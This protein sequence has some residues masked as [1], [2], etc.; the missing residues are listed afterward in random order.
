M[1]MFLNYQNIADNYRPNNLVCSF[2]VGKSYTKLDPVDASKPFEEYDAKGDLIG[3]S[4]RYG[5]TLNLEFNIDGEIVVES[6]CIIYAAHN[7]G[8]T[9]LTAGYVGRRA[10]NILD[11]ISW[12]CIAVSPDE[13]VFLWEQ[14]EIFEHDLENATDS[15][16]VSA[17]DYL[18]D[19]HLEL[20]ICNFRYETVFSKVFE[21]TSKL[22]FNIDSILSKQLVKGIYYCELTVLGDDLVTPIFT[23][24]DC[25]FL[26]K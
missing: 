3:Y 2:P 8:P 18:A 1:G 11:F 26:V 4:W 9:A 22:I 17:T 10:Y 19:K 12:T 23:K 25:V 5:E 14:D 15:V 16:Y 21:G 13:E 7:D 20:K 6:D 24:N